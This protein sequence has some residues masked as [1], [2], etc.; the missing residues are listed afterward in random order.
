MTQENMGIALKMREEI[1][2]KVYVLSSRL[3]T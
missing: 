2:A 3:P 1:A